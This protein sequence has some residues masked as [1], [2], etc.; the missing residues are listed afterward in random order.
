MT[1]ASSW[2]S[3]RSAA[4]SLGSVE[5]CRPLLRSILL[6]KK[7]GSKQLL[8]NYGMQHL[9]LIADNNG[10]SKQAEADKLSLFIGIGRCS[11][12]HIIACIQQA[13]AGLVLWCNRLSAAL[14]QCL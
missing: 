10:V 6:E 2:L 14:L 8:I 13:C 1:P 3:S 12:N 5:M 4:A 7:F 9:G 11:R